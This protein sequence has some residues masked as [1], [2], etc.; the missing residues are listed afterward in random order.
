MELL[1]CPFCGSELDIEDSDTFHASTVGWKN[2]G[3]YREYVNF[4]EVP[5]DQWC[6]EVHCCTIYGG[7]GA[8]ITAD[9]RQEAIDK[10]NT[11]SKV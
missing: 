8:S 9:S 7:C 5:K 1:N 11:R 10:W 2:R 6:H 4:R 3:E